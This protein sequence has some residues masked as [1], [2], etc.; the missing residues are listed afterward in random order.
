MGRDTLKKPLF[1]LIKALWLLGRAGAHEGQWMM[2]R[3]EEGG[4]E[5]NKAV[6]YHLK[7]THVYTHRNNTVN[8]Q[9]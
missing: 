7:N 9:V 2:G 5:T 6:K 3:L 8:E 4:E 1:S